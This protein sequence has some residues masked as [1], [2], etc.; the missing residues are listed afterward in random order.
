MVLDLIGG[1]GDYYICPL[2]GAASFL[3]L[4]GAVDIAISQF[5]C[6]NVSVRLG[7][8][9]DIR[10]GAAWMVLRWPY[11]TPSAVCTCQAF[12]QMGAA[13]A[14][15]MGFALMAMPVLRTS[16]FRMAADNAITS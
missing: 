15:T 8:C 5:N 2:G 14:S 16:V 7:K 12:A 1:R 6:A 13:S 11:A 9:C 3:V 4:D 10:T